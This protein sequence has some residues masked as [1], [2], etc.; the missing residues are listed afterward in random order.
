NVPFG[1][2]KD[3]DL[4]VV[5]G[6]QEHE[7][8][9]PREDIFEITDVVK[10]SDTIFVSMSLYAEI[11]V[12]Q[13]VRMDSSDI[14]KVKILFTKGEF[15]Q[16]NYIISKSSHAEVIKSSEKFQ[17]YTEYEKIFGNVDDRDINNIDHAIRLCRFDAEDVETWD[18]DVKYDP[19]KYPV[20]NE[21]S[22]NDVVK[23]WSRKRKSETKAPPEKIFLSI[24]L[25]YR[26]RPLTGDNI[27]YKEIMH[28]LIIGQVITFIK[29]FVFHTEFDSSLLH[30][31]VFVLEEAGRDRS[32]TYVISTKYPRFCVIEIEPNKKS[33]IE[34]PFKCGLMLGGQ[35]EISHVDK[36]ELGE[37]AFGYYAS[38]RFF[39]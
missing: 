22:F 38:A 35:I 24:G 37:G 36:I 32:Q 39:H 8:L 5:I 18:S 33:W 3:M 7:V 9:L 4:H 14:S 28:G 29:P 13:I 16:D 15:Q 11:K 30:Q 12:Q 34:L 6:Q 31:S 20:V 26:S 19:T 10:K 23:W 2:Y 17:I 25:N 21:K 27:L 1:P